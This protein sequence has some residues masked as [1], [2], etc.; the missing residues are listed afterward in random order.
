MLITNS[1]DIKNNITVATKHNDKALIIQD[2]M[3]NLFGALLINPISIIKSNNTNSANKTKDKLT[4][5]TGVLVKV[6]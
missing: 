6:R 2:R 1:L 3:N 5:S 4:P